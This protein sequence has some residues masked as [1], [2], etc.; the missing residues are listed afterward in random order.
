MPDIQTTNGF[1]PR[2]EPIKKNLDAFATSLNKIDEKNQQALKQR[3]AIDI[4]LSQVNLDSSEDS[5]KS[6]YAQKI[7]DAIDNEAQ[8]GDYS[9]ALNTATML[10]GT[11]V[12]SPELLGRQKAFAE[13]EEAKKLVNS[14]NINETTK[15]RWEEQNAY[16][17]QDTYDP[18]TGKI[19]GGTRWKANWNPVAP[20]DYVGVAA[21]AI[22]LA[23]PEHKGTS[24]SSDIG[25]SNADGSSKRTGSSSGFSYSKLTAD[26]IKQNFN[27]VFAS[28]PGAY[29][30]LMQDYDDNVWLMNKKE[31]ELSQMDP[32]SAG[33]ETVKNEYN[34]I[35]S[36]MTDKNGIILKDP[37]AYLTKH[38]SPILYNAAYYNTDSSSSISKST[39]SA[40]TTS[41][42]N[43]K[44]LAPIPESSTT[45]TSGPMVTYGGIDLAS[46]DITNANRT[47]QNILQH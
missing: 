34:D 32:N 2:R 3:T 37:Y 28:T 4:A 45:V 41:G 43:G 5:W 15:Q 47:V 20:T 6:Q 36:K 21:K 44:G 35:K 11:A 19:I 7:K 16:N 29:E 13:R 8:Y 25:N 31:K 14:M 1:V 17:Y 18:I 30:S 33:Y 22:Q 40:V 38:I 26:K 12:S 46:P 39:S 27:A 23:A 10:A 24:S 9:R 42:K